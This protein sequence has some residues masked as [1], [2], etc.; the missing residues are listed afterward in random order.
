MLET[1]GLFPQIPHKKAVSPDEPNVAKMG[2]PQEP[3]YKTEG[4]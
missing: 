2:Q 3:V 4:G 1:L